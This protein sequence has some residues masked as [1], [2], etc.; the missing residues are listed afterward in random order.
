MR[1]DK[2]TYARI[3]REAHSNCVICGTNDPLGL[4]LEFKIETDNSMSVFVRDGSLFQGYSD[5]MHG[6]IISVLFDAAMTHCLFAHGI[7]GV[8]ASLNVRFR[9]A[10]IPDRPIAVRAHIEKQKSHLC[11]LEGTLQQD[12]ELKSSAKAKFWIVSQEVMDS[13][14]A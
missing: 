10:V 11:L 4:G 6:G 7:V 13:E 14:K 12:G 9:Q 3:A 2:T 1:T 8:T 5:R